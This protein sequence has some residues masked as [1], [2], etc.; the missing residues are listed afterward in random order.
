M[1][2]KRSL[3]YLMVFYVIW[4]LDFCASHLIWHFQC[5]SG[6]L[7][8]YLSLEAER[9]AVLKGNAYLR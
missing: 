6:Q 5:N 7:Q 4:V 9:K 8:N 3:L 1:V 2:L